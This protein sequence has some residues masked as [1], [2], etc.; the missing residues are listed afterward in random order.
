MTLFGTIAGLWGIAMIAVFL[1]AIRLS[2]AIERRLGKI[3]G[4]GFPVNTNLL[5]SAF[6]G[7]ANEDSEL[8]AM[9]RRLRRLLAVVVIGFAL[10]GA[11]F[12]IF[13]PHAANT[14]A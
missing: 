12:W 13:A 9:R 6:G 8:A 3:G 1:Q 11:A 7:R 5:A 4:W 10:F 14:A 2:Y